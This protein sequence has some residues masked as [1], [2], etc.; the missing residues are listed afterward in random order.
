MDLS[1]PPLGRVLGALPLLALPLRQPPSGNVWLTLGTVL[2]DNP[3]STVLLHARMVVIALTLLFGAWLSWWTRREFGAPVALLALFLFVF[4]PNIIAHGHIV[5]TDLILSFS[6]FLACTLWTDFLQEPSLAALVPAVGGLGLALISKYSALFL[7]TV[8]PPLYAVAW[9]RKRGQAF[10][11]LHG[12]IGVLLF[13]IMGAGAIIALAYAPATIVRERSSW[14]ADGGPPVSTDAA[15]QSV[16]LAISVRRVLSELRSATSPSS[17]R[18]I[19]GLNQ[20]FEHNSGGQP[21][22]LLG[23]FGSHGWWQYFPVAFMVKTLTGAL[24]ACLLATA[25][26]LYFRKE[27]AP[28]LPLVC[29]TLPPAIY[30]LLAMRF[31]IDL[32]VRHILPIYAFLYV[33]ASFMLI[34]YG[35]HLLGRAWPY[36]IAALM[37]LTCTES[38]LSYPHYLAFFNWPSG[39]S[40]N[41]W[42]YL[43]DSNLDWGQDTDNLRRYVERN[44]STPLCT[45]LFGYTPHNYFGTG[46]RNLL[47]TGTPEGVENLNCVVAVSAN[48]VNGLYIGPK[49]FATLRQR[50]PF[51]K[52]GFSIYLYDLRHQGA[53]AANGTG[54]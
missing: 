11:T 48:F 29:V 21:S 38:L 13:T 8:L 35:Q 36:A 42:H 49:A 18:Y 9:W 12:A 51:A 53:G 19:Q 1:H 10:F 15:I 45:A 43:L 23:Q 33:F 14:A 44:G 46:W 16:S 4:D 7:L 25:S 40:V 54:Q 6:I 50:K 26:L 31:S 24:L 2:W 39:G 20:L 32:G 17:F 28:F 30:F 41:G 5:T 37:I 3:P 22:Y 27:T 34:G 52:I 47:V